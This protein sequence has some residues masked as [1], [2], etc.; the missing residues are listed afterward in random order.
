MGF[1]FHICV[2]M[3]DVYVWCLCCFD[4]YVWCFVVVL[5]YCLMFMFMFVI[6]F[7][8]Y[9]CC[10][11]FVVCWCLAPSWDALGGIWCKLRPTLKLFLWLLQCMALAGFIFAI[12][13]AS[14]LMLW[15]P[16]APQN[17]YQDLFGVQLGPRHAICCQ[18]GVRWGGLWG[19]CCSLWRT[20]A[21]VVG[22]AGSRTHRKYCAK[23]TVANKRWRLKMWFFTMGPWGGFWPA[24]FFP[25]FWETPRYPRRPPRR[26]PRGHYHPQ[27]TQTSQMHSSE[28]SK[29]KTKSETVRR[30]V[31]LD[32]QEWYMTGK[33]YHL[34]SL[35]NAHVSAVLKML[36]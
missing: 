13:L 23:R 32:G 16:H 18:V 3:I 8:V 27:T 4:V 21:G 9:V 11:L 24:S 25:S 6:L 28:R 19:P 14:F 7:D 15:Q 20:S 2:F 30:R 17:G 5:F 33:H 26:P 35:I 36:R 1:I 29:L 31:G 34:H 10:L 22:E 12:I